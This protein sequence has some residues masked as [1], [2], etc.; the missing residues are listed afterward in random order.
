MGC[1]AQSVYTIALLET[2]HAFDALV[3]V[4]LQ[5]IEVQPKPVRHMAALLPVEPV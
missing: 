1:R 5:L 3:R 2:N 4:K